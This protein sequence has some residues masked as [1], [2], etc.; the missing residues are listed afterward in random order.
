L[1][2]WHQKLTFGES[3]AGALKFA[4]SM[5]N[6]EKLQGAIAIIGGTPEERCNALQPR[7]WT[8]SNLEGSPKDVFP[9][10]LAL[11]I[12]ELSDNIG[13]R[14]SVLQMLYGRYDGV[15]EEMANS[16]GRTLSRLTEAANTH[17]S[18]RVWAGSYDPA[19]LCGLYFICDL[20]RCTEVPLSVVFTPVIQ[21]S[22]NAITQYRSTG[23]IPPEEFGDLA[24]NEKQISIFCKGF[25]ADLWN[26]L[27]RENAPL[28]TVIN[29]KVMSVSEDFYDF[30][31][32][33]N[34]PESEFVAARVLGK[35]LNQIPGV[36]DAWLYL[37]LQKMVKSGLLKKVAPPSD[38]HPY[39]GVF[40]LTNANCNS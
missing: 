23:E 21:E 10:T 20:L 28:R 12:G 16:N 5:K 15:A 31:L 1:T 14:L 22:G 6:G 33:A 11:D 35:A 4:K 27:V 36:S 24:A 32:I 17:E 39:S 7:I 3:P 19:E 18:V 8:G 40:C 2:D 9:L 29:G 26:D 13:D 37:R 25:Y 38:D 30:L 34:M